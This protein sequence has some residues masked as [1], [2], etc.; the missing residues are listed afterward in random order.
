MTTR[1]NFTRAALVLGAAAPLAGS[2]YATSGAALD[3]DDL[4]R[5]VAR[6]DDHV[7]AIELAQWIKD[8]RSGLRVIDLRSKEAFD[9]GQIP[10]AEHMVVT[11]LSTETFKPEETIVLYSEGGAHAGQA[12][13]F[14]RARGLRQVYFLRS[15]AHEWAE[16]VLSPMLPVDATAAER[17]AFERAVPLSQYFGGRPR[18][19]VPRAE[20]TT[21]NVS[22]KRRGC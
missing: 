15:G 20:Y 12:W 6:G 11:A 3:I 5:A 18:R 19:N 7:D 17:A 2:P 13:V 22:L 10:T 16:Q 9:E 4:A 8:R 14:L 21:A 1:R